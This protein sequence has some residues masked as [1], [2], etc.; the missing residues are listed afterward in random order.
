MTTVLQKFQYSSSSETFV[1]QI[2]PW[3]MKDV[4]TQLLGHSHCLNPNVLPKQLRNYHSVLVQTYKKE[5]GLQS[6]Q[7]TRE[8]I[9]TT[10]RPIWSLAWSKS[11][12]A[13]LVKIHLWM[14]SLRNEMLWKYPR[15]I[16]TMLVAS[17]HGILRPNQDRKLASSSGA[18]QNIIKH[19]IQILCRQNHLAKSW[20]G[21]L[22]FPRHLFL[23]KRWQLLIR[24]LL[25]P[26]LNYILLVSLQKT[27]QTKITW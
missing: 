4:I 17:C 13:A 15:K 24:I 1:Q 5:E 12:K 14:P 26:Q 10:A 18:S 11:S 3:G 16:G 9:V 23:P 20:K 25:L 19:Y 27:P 22:L 7:A 2:C 21:N 6:L 8:C